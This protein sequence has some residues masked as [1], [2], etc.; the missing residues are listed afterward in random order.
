MPNV[1]RQREAESEY[2]NHLRRSERVWNRWSEWYKLSE[3]DFEPIRKELIDDL[4]LEPGDRVLEIGCGPGVNFRP[5]REAVCDDGY[6][7]AVDYSPEMIDK[8]EERISTNSW[9]NVEAV[10]ADATTA[11]LGGPYDAAIATLAVSIMPDIERVVRNIH[12]VLKPDAPL[13]VLDIREVQSGPL[14]ILNPFLRWFLRWYANWNST[15][16]VPG[17]IDDIFDG[18]DQFNT[19]MSGTIY[20]VKATRRP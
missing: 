9:E 4:C 2:R 17:T 7:V 18:Y 11:D 20:T 6:L 5:I 1:D 12:S 14:R 13:G 8:A 16:D 19:Y 15:G 3:Q 10:R